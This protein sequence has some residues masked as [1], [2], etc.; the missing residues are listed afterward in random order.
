MVFRTFLSLKYMI[1]HFAH[2]IFVKFSLKQYKIERLQINPRM[3][4]F[5]KNGTIFG[6][7]YVTLEDIHVMS[8]VSGQRIIV[9]SQTDT[10]KGNLIQAPIWKSHQKIKLK[11]V[12]HIQETKIC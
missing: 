11:I 1:I 5:P 6:M 8:P 12:F 7:C 3:N 9:Q 2:T 10:R 4:L